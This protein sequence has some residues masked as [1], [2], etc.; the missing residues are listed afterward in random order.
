MLDRL[1]KIKRAVRCTVSFLLT[2]LFLAWLLNRGEPGTPLPALSK[3][4]K[5]RNRPSIINIPEHLI[6]YLTLTLRL[7]YDC[8]TTTQESACGGEIEAGRPSSYTQI[9]A[10]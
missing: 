5:K 8:L 7:P 9:Q 1:S 4:E 6:Y 3:E 10:S 2:I